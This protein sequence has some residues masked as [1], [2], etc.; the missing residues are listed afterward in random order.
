MTP[1]RPNLPVRGFTLVEAVVVI[2]VTG[3]L[4][5][6]IALFLRWPM[7][8]YVDSVRRAEMTDIADTA[9]RRIGRDLRLALPNSVRVTTNG[10]D[11]YLEFIPT[12]AG[13][14]YRAEGT[15]N[16]DFTAPDTTSDIIGPAMTFQAGDE[17]VVYNLGGPGADAYTG[18]NR[19]AYVGALG[20]PVG[21]VTIAARQFP[22]ASP[23]SR[24]QVVTQ[25]VTY[26]CQPATGTLR[27]Y[28]GYGFQAAQPNDVSA[29]P[30]AGASRALLATSVSACGFTYAA[31][32]TERGGLVSLQLSLTQ[33]GETV[34]LYHEVH[35][36]NVP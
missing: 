35:V 27:R 31:G 20:A 2:A 32:A 8:G 19:S 4:A 24:F 18:G 26:V 3:A 11:Q 15:D 23:G 36:A 33:E 7:Q 9:L 30:L 22:F 12:R 1:S 21:N 25:P 10:A 17:I 14:R 34:S 5:A 6:V 13:G 29:A 28:W 16:L